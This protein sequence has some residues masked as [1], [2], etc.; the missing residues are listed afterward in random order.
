MVVRN[1]VDDH[2][3]NIVAVER[4]FRARIAQTDPELHDPG[5]LNGGLRVSAKPAKH[6]V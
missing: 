6:F 5:L 1:R 3:S 2:K 4:V